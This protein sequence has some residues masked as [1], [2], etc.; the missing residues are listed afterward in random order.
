[1]FQVALYLENAK[2]RMVISNFF[3][4][5]FQNRKTITIIGI[6]K[7]CG[8]IIKFEISMF[9]N[10]FG[11]EFLFFNFISKDGKISIFEPENNGLQVAE[12][13]SYKPL[14]TRFKN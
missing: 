11:I 4:F 12:I 14:K 8:K 10:K 9:L 7:T 5:K 6:R 1:M 13:S 3:V 2:K